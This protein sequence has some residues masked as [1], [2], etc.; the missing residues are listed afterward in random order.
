MSD[1]LALLVPAPLVGERVD[2]AVALVTGRTRAEAAAL[3]DA[4]A[5]LVAGR[6]V[7]R[8]RRLQAGETLEIA[9]PPAHAAELALAPDAGVAF[10]VVHEDPAFV[11]VDKPAGVVVHPGAGQ[12]TGTLAAG[13]LARFPDLAAHVQSG[14][15]EPERPGLVHR[16]DKDTSGLLV[17]ARTPEALASLS[18]QLA[19]RT[20]RRTYVALVLGHLGADEGTIDAPLGRSARTPTKVAVRADG[21]EARTHYRVAERLV[22]PPAT[23]LCTVQLETGRTH[24]IRVHFAAIGHPVAGDTRYGGARRSLHLGRPFLHA[25]SLGFLHPVT[26]A[27]VEYAAPL[28]AELVDALAR[29]GGQHGGNAREP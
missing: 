14:A 17:V 20:M 27:P 5:V 29:L 22:G 9:L 28:P 18:S 11:V 2:R 4:G 16:L 7:A 6:S 12:R 23:T 13:L 21:R 8:A 3:V 19:A 26:G 1:P 24:Q 25:A 10:G 15:F